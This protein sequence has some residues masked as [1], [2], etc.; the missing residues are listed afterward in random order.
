[1]PPENLRYLIG[2][3]Y[4]LCLLAVMFAVLWLK[5]YFWLIF[6]TALTLFIISSVMMHIVM[7]LAQN[8]RLVGEDAIEESDE[9]DTPPQP[10]PKP[11]RAR[12]D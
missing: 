8:A 12:I 6:G 10:P 5:G 1:M 4:R 2:A 9:D 11:L 7:E 3:I